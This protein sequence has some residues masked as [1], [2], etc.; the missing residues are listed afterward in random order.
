[1]AI[2]DAQ[3][4]ELVS[5]YVG[6][7]D[8]APDPAGL[9]YWIDVIEAGG[10]FTEIA[11]AFANSAE[12][13]ALYPYMATPDVGTPTTF[14]TSIYAN[15]FN[16]T[17]D[18]DGLNFWIEALTEG[19][20]TAGEMIQAI[21]GGA[22]GTD[23]DIVN[24]KST[25]ALN[26][27]TT[28]ANT[29]NFTWDSSAASSSAD[30]IGAVTADAASVATA[31]A[32]ATNYLS[33]ATTGS[34]LTLTTNIDNLTGTSGADTF[35]GDDTT[36]SAADQIAGNAGTDTLRLF[37]TGTNDIA[38]PGVMTSV[39][40]VYIH[41]LGN[42]L[43]IS[44]STEIESLE[45]DALDTA[46]TVTASGSQSIVLDSTNVNGDTTIAYATTVTASTIQVDGFDSDGGG[47]DDIVLTGTGL[48]SVS[49]EAVNDD[50]TITNLDTDATATT[51]N[52]NAN[53]AALTIT[54]SDEGGDNKVTA[55]NVTGSK[56]AAITNA[57]ST[58]VTSI[59]ASGSTGGF[60]ASMAGLAAAATFTG[61]TG[62]DT[63]TA[64]NTNAN[65]IDMGA[66]DDT[67]DLN[68]VVAATTGSIG[69]GEGTDTLVFDDA[70]A[71][72]I[73][74]AN[75]GVFSSFEKMKAEVSTDTLDF[76]ALSTF[77]AFEAGTSTALTL[78]NLST[79]A[80]ADVLVSG[81]QTT[82]MALNVK[83]AIDIGT[84][85][86]LK[87]TLDHIANDTAVTIADLQIDGVETLDIV[88]E[89]A[90]TNTNT[91]EIGTES[92]DLNQINVSG[93]SKITITDE[94]D[95][96]GQQTIDASAATGVVT[97]IFDADTEGTAIT[98]GS[99]N[100]V[101]EANSGADI[102][103]G[104]AG[105]DTIVF[106]NS[107]ANGDKLTGGEGND[108]FKMATDTAATITTHTINDFDFGGS[109][110]AAD[111]LQFSL[112]AL[113]GLT[114]VTQISDTS[115]NDAAAT[116][117]TV[118]TLSSDGATIANAD[119]VILNQSYADA[120]AVL[121]GLQTAGNSTITFGGTLEDNDAIL[122]AY[123]DGTDGYI[124]V[125]T[126]GAAIAS[127]DGIDSVEN[128]VKLTGVTDF[129]SFDSSDFAFIA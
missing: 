70:S 74:T 129:S 59:D 124:A 82:S 105:N 66:G 102:I 83:D 106:E 89:G 13:R 68:A 104:G 111:I 39:E 78:N 47:D 107:T 53:G 122:V 27:T 54:E 92:N 77:T 90:G 42:A 40:Q 73:T 25:A 51:L 45:L 19:R 6:Y 118:A 120:A 29:P 87:L 100:D 101:L 72:L 10:S 4:Q 28:A 21:I 50:S 123:T 97:V 103:I 58:A 69:G 22:Q 11:D 26:F 63:I 33:G 80:A 7:F 98:G 67:V 2:T 79:T 32:A 95:I 60:S 108:T 20:A 126:A 117:G 93:S 86:T 128:V 115:N 99:G 30:I 62:A 75:K 41:D 5:L 18:T 71:T 121:T 1:M 31:E 24:N 48:Q 113:E 52:L 56:A 8:R 12:S 88:S 127:S 16:R 94:G 114:T 55:I 91:V 110:T 85:D 17:P 43:N 61:G 14:I 64:I 15:L 34:T 112:T 49:I 65:T 125:A 57:L 36:L 81:V 37:D 76:E 46:I 116:D 109:S 35:V 44:G 9:Q 84:D 3:K 119:L 38:L 96:T 23:A